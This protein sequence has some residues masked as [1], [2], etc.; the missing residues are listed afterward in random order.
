MTKY[1]Q[2]LVSQGALDHYAS[3]SMSGWDGMGLLTNQVNILYN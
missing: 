2:A 3:T 1:S